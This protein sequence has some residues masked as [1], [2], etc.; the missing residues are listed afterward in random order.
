MKKSLFSLLT[1][2]FCLTNISAQQMSYYTDMVGSPG[3]SFIMAN[4]TNLVFDIDLN[5]G[6]T[7]INQ[8]WNFQGLDADQLDTLN[9]LTPTVQEGIDFPG[10]NLINESNVGRIAFDK[11]IATGLFLQGISLDFAG[12]PASLNYNPPQKTLDDVNSIGTTFNTVSYVDENIYVGISQNAFGCQVDIDSIEIKRRSDYTVNFDATGELRMPLDTFDYALRAMTTEI[13]LDSIFI[14]CPTGIS[15][16][17]CTLLGLSAPVGWSLA[18]DALIQFSGFAAGAVTLDSAFTAVF[19]VPYTIS[20]VCIIDLNYDSAYTD[21]NFYTARFKGDNT[22]DIGFEQVDQI[23]LNVYPN[24][25]ASILNLQTDVV[26]TDASI[27]I[28]N[29]QGQQVRT[30]TL[31]GSNNVDVSALTN[32]MYYYQLVKGK[33]LLH[34]GKFMIEK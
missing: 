27:F 8:I 28:Y 34:F 32:G 6:A 2:A 19:Y 33:T 26:L 17:S 15:G 22:P 18:P 21:T 4:D 31:N 29:A 9:F 25:T 13:T 11:N 20:P 14:Y 3:Q 12:T 5:T 24:P 23:S 30:Q 7:G 16:P 1:A 10:V